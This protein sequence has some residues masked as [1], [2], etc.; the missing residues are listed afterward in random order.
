MDGQYD[1]PGYSAYYCTVTAI[2]AVT[3]KIIGFLT[4][5]K[6][7][8]N[9]ISSNAEPLAFCRLLNELQSLHVKIVSVTTDNSTTLNKMFR[10]E[11]P[12]I[13]HNFDMWHILRNIFKKFASKFKTKVCLF[14]SFIYL[15]LYYTFLT[16]C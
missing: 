16:L 12:Y 11:Y 1:S 4:V 7:E 14:T 8:V 15:Q 6:S 13:R 9:N 3:R 2:E 10:E 5:A